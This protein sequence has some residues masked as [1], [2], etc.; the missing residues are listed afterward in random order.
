MS[1]G[2]SPVVRAVVDVVLDVIEVLVYCQA[3]LWRQP[4]T[5]QKRFSRLNDA[6]DGIVCSSIRDN[7]R[8]PPHRLRIRRLCPTKDLRRIAQ[9]KPI[10]VAK[11]LEPLLVVDEVLHEAAADDDDDLVE[12]FVLRPHD[13]L[14]LLDSFARNLDQDAL[15]DWEHVLPIHERRWPP[16]RGDRLLLDSR[17]APLH[18]RSCV[19]EAWPL[20]FEPGQ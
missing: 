9:R 14:P 17:L 3:Q 10:V 13:V 12:R 1:W 20:T 11:G 19:E 7:K 18:T 6:N 15:E 8:I 16:I 2:D 4:A 5:V